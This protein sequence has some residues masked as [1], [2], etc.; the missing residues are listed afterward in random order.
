MGA[1]GDRSTKQREQNFR[2][3]NQN[4]MG[5]FIMSSF[6]FHGSNEMERTK[7]NCQGYIGRE[8]VQNTVRED[9]YRNEQSSA[10]SIR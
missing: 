4:V 5:Y 8:A 1:E 2:L 10:N 6:D 3:E 9:H 7:S